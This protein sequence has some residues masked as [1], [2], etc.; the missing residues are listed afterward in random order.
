[1]SLTRAYYNEHDPAKAAW[2]REL[3]RAGLITPGDVD[4]RSIVD[5][6]PADVVG[7]TRCHFFAGIG[8][9]DYAL[10]CAGW[11]DDRI[12]WSGSCP[13]QSFSAAG[14]G[15][16][17]DD[18]RHLWPA[19]FRLI[20][21]C[22]PSVVFGEQVEAAVRHGWL[23]LVFADLEGAAYAV[24]ASSLCAAGA[25]APH[26][27]QRVYFVAES[28]LWRRQQQP[29]ARSASV[30]AAAVDAAE[31]VQ[32]VGGHGASVGVLADAERGTT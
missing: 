32:P 27:R 31:C 30:F 2:L 25:G 13:C 21:E 19:W 14:R 3:M 28:E 18:P 5:V 6:R 20:A 4:E 16:G 11:P 22:R 15:D 9:W 23:D 10:T 29:G 17:G 1:M 7:Y 26:L 8:V 24:A 12:V